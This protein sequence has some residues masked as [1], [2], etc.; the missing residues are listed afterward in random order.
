MIHGE[1]GRRF[2]G[3]RLYRRLLDRTGRGYWWS[4]DAQPPALCDRRGRLS[5]F[6]ELVGERE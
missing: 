4:R 2:G 6:V 5:V 1:N 3:A